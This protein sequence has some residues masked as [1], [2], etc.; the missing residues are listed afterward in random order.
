MRVIFLGTPSFAVHPLRA[1]VEAGHE[2]V[3]VVTQPD[4]PAGRSRTRQPPPVKQAAIELGLHVL[5]PETLRDE[6]VVEQLQQL[7]PNVGIVA[8]Y[9]EILRKNVLDIPGLGYL[10]I[11][12]SLLPLYRGPTPVSAAILGG[13]DITGV[14]I[15]KLV[16]AMDAGPLLAQATVP[17]AGDAR[18]GPLTDQL[19]ELG[20]QLLINILPLYANG[21]LQP[22]PQD[23]GQATYCKMLAKEDGRIHWTQPAIVIERAI[24]AYDPWPGTFT[25]WQG[26]PLKIGVAR[27]DADW[28]GTEPPGTVLE[29]PSLRV[30]TGSGALEVLELQPAGKR[31]LNAGDWLRGQRGLVGQR[32]GK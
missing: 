32:L 7:A 4:R 21:E 29:G 13:D 24:R 19:F 30:A 20:A 5:Q 31:M 11:H 12:P 9:G 22:Q 17:L 18:T 15:I 2:V 1:L 8:A 26:Q 16:R 28:Q 6:A 10:N 23:E 25:T 3:G 27:V 14:S